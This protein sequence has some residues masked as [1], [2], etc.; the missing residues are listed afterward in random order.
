VHSKSHGIL[1]G[2]L[3]VK[4]NLPSHL[5]QGI[6]STP[7]E[8][9]VVMRLS[10][11]PGDI[12]DDSVSTPRG[13]AV[14]IMGVDGERLADSATD[15]TQ[16]FLLVNGPAFLKPDAKSFAGSLKLLAKT[17]DKAEGLKK[18]LSAALRGTE[19]II[20][21]VG[22]QSP[23][24]MSLGGHPETHILGETFYSQVPVLYGQYMAKVSVAPVSPELTALT[25]SPLNVNGVPNGLRDAVNEFFS[26]RSATW[27]VRVQLCTN[28]ETMPIEDASVVWPEE[29]SPY[30]TV[31]TIEV[32]PQVAWDE[33]V[34]PV[35]EDN[36]AFS[37][38]NA[39]SAHRP[40][41]SVMR[42][43]K[44]TYEKSTI[45]RKQFNG[46][47]IGETGLGEMRVGETGAQQR[48]S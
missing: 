2:K 37:P 8:Y 3:S 15:N 11:S 12:L 19:K 35:I 34:S 33:T 41:G 24:I 18:V 23:A 39:I 30:V 32:E 25:K 38:W 7:A 10:T 14:K 1:R 29:E 47:P 36:L 13:L 40:L 45:F 31:A 27:E 42:A 17:T 22:G 28:L 43:R 16:D 9:N 20:E 5:A 46:C 44:L 6:F 4:P 21:S 48:S 26:T